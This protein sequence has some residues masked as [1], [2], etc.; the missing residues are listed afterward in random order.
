MQKKIVCSVSEVGKRP[1]SFGGVGV[2]VDKILS[3]GTYDSF[4]VIFNKFSTMI[5]YK[6]TPRYLQGLPLIRK[7]ET[8]FFPY[9]FEED[10]RE[11]HLVDFAEF[12]LG[13]TLYNAIYEGSASELAGR[14]TAMDNATRNATDVIKRLSIAYNRGRQAAI[15]TELTEIISGAAAV[16]KN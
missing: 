8:K 1:I 14:M 7:N 11:Q 2:I 9:D 6:T 4:T 3:S 13:T 10:M 15:T 12:H 16:Q 5:S